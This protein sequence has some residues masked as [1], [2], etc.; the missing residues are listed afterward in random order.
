M[1]MPDDEMRKKL[2]V[3]LEII[4]SVLI[5]AALLHFA[6]ISD[7]VGIISNIRPEWLL[8]SLLFLLFTHI[9]MSY[10]ITLVLD[11]L[12]SPV[13]FLTALKC[14][15]AG[16]LASDFT[17]AR[18]G[19]FTTAF[20]LSRNHSV[21]MEKG[22]ISI[23]GPQMFDFGLKVVA[24]GVALLYLMYFYIP[25]GPSSPLALTG[26]AVIALMIAVGMLLLFSKRFARFL[27]FISR[28]PFGLGDKLHS[29]ILKMQEN[30]HAIK[31][32]FPEI[33][34][35]L[36]FTWLCKGL[37]WYGIALSVGV[38]VDFPYPFLFYLF[39]QPLIS[40]LEF[41]PTPTLAGMGL[42]EAGVAVVLSLFGVPLPIGVS[43]GILIRFAGMVLNAFGISEGVRMLGI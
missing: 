15:L 12:K 16:M 14:H 11:Y 23:L 28:I 36:L 10:R 35:L 2:S 30:S 29:L 18:S 5:L 40:M 39:L 27:A 20:A 7:V 17:P 8:V 21:P 24:G 13:S 43:Y 34:L 3:A 9:G 26:V 42:S 6:G 33:T 25:D 31:A 1:D 38:T 37:S 22:V 41:I 4:I 19:Y 32:L